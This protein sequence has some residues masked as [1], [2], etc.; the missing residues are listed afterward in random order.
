[1]T[2]RPI[3]N[4]V[5]LFKLKPCPF[6]NSERIYPGWVQLTDVD[7]GEVIRC[8]QCRA[9]GPV[10]SSN[11]YTPKEEQKRMKIQAMEAWN[12]RPREEK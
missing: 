12:F 3:E 2:S 5:T 4:P 7:S 11:Y 9:L 1:M 6:C 8:R 10:Y